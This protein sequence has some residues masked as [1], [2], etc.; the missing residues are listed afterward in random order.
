MY[1]CVGIVRGASREE[2]YPTTL[3]EERAVKYQL[4]LVS[5]KAGGKLFWYINDLPCFHGRDRYEK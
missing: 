1:V 3:C 4:F 5:A 2:R